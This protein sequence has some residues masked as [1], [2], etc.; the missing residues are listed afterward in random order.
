MKVFLLSRGF[1]SLYEKD[2]IY[3]G[4][5]I[6][7]WCPRCHTALSDIEVEHEDTD[8]KLYYIRY[9]FEDGSGYV[10]VATT[11]PETMLG[12]TAV[13]VNPKDDRYGHLVG[14]ILVL[15][16]VERRISIVADDYV[17]PEFGTG[18]VKVTPA[19]DPNDFWIGE[20]HGLESVVVLDEDG[21]MNANA[22]KYDGYERYECRKAIIEEL[23][24]KGLLEK[25]TEHKH[26]VGHCQRCATVVEP[27][28]QNSGL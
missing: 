27:L 6:I 4:D 28:C 10:I 5:Y 17:D 26:A 9:P 25:I 11:R 22:G 19:H 3:Q 7:N 16:I 18:A 13:A 8:G 12:D 14:K 21:R 24:S 23:E 15:P 1:V 20:R 2:L